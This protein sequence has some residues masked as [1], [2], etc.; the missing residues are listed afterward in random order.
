MLQQDLQQL[1]LYATMYAI[2]RM[3]PCWVRRHWPRGSYSILSCTQPNGGICG[4]VA[5]S[6][7][8]GHITGGL[9]FS[10]PTM[11]YMFYSHLKH[12]LIICNCYR[13]MVSPKKTIYWDKVLMTAAVRWESSHCASQHRTIW[14]ERMCGDIRCGYCVWKNSLK[15]LTHHFEHRRCWWVWS[16]RRKTNYY[17]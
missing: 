17:K 9:F 6:T 16:F 1:G 4:Q 14:V 7:W 15:Y 5:T 11:L 13:Q 12:I 2:S 8:P 3:I 10:C